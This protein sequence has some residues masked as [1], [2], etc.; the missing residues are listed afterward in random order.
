MAPSKWIHSARAAKNR[1]ALV[2]AR[3]GHRHLS[4]HRGT[5]CSLQAHEAPP[6]QVQVRERAGSEQP[7][8]VLRYAPVSHLRESED[9]FDDPDAVPDL[10]AHS[11]FGPVLRPLDFI[12]HPLPTIAPIGEVT[13]LRG[14][15]TDNRSLPL[16]RRVTATRV[17]CPWSKSG[18]LTES[19]TLAGVAVTAWMSLVLL[20]TPKCPFIPKYHGCPCG[21]DASRDSVY[22]R[23]SL[24][25]TAH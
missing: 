8:G 22:H 15:F 6:N 14:A 7:I 4:R 3:R 10:R 18:R 16:I 5:S 23:D 2:S 20:S 9:P 24:S 21:S 12:D 17:C 11:R 1:A 13:C 19:W 25:R